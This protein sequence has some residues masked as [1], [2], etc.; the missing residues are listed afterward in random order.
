MISV[1]GSLN[2]GHDDLAD[3]L[4]QHMTDMSNT[5]DEFGSFSHGSTSV[6]LSPNKS[7]FQVHL[8]TS[9]LLNANRGSVR[10]IFLLSFQQGLIHPIFSPIQAIGRVQRQT[11]RL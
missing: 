2:L 8:R 5:I 10:P 9:I 6:Q 1:F 4:A 7:H 3:E 11:L